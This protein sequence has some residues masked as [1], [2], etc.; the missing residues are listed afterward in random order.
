MSL[1]SGP[2]A[3]WPTPCRTALYYRG[4]GIIERD[5]RL[6]HGC[7]T[8]GFLMTIMQAR[9]SPTVIP[10]GAR[11]APFGKASGAEDMPFL[12]AILLR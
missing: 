6:R 9:S 8:N 12:R 10:L 7:V 4:G 1:K 11:D 5:S 3:A 2:Q